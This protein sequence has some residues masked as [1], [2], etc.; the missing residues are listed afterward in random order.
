[1][2]PVI[3]ISI[4]KFRPLLYF[5]LQFRILRA[6]LEF[7]IISSYSLAIFKKFQFYFQFIEHKIK[8]KP[9]AYHDKKRIPYD[10]LR[11]YCRLKC[12]I[13]KFFLINPLL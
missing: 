10:I 11:K 9:V 8:L 3:K 13:K 1:M 5:I 6:L 12:K 2:V 7:I 4:F